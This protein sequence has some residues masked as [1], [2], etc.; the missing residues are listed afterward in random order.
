MAWVEKDLKDYLV[1]TPL[2]CAGSP[3]T[4]PGCP[5]LE[6]INRVPMHVQKCVS[7]GKYNFPLHRRMA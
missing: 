5:G 3:T 2:S 6:I 1:S 7:P 4:R